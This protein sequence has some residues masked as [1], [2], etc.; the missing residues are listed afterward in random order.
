MTRTTSTPTRSNAGEEDAGLCDEELYEKEIKRQDDEKDNEFFTT[1]TA[2]GVFRANSAEGTLIRPLAVCG[3]LLTLLLIT[4][5]YL[6][7]DLF[8]P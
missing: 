2:Y 6:V 7:Y 3:N 1:V 8:K 5:G 4:M